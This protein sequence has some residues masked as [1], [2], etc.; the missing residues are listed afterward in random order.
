MKSES[1]L[2]IDTLLCAHV[3]WNCENDYVCNQ[4]KSLKYSF[5]A[6]VLWENVFLKCSLMHTL[7]NICAIYIVIFM[8]L[9]KIEFLIS[10]H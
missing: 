3:Q 7:I 8:L 4:N 6:V 10:Y 5:C 2:K 9:D 1:V